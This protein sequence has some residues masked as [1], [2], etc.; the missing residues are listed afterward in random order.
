MPVDRELIL[1]ET[2]AGLGG[3]TQAQQGL[4][5]LNVGAAALAIGLG[6][7]VK[8]GKDAVDNYSSQETA[9]LGLQQAT[10]TQKLNYDKVKGSVEDF[11]QT[12]KAYISN[13]YD[14]IAAAGNIVRAGHDEKDT[15]RLLNDAL[16]L[17]A[18][19]HEDVS[20]AAKQLVL[21]ENGNAKAL[22]ELG[23]STTEYS[24][25]MKNKKL[26]AEQKDAELLALIESK[27][28]N[29]RDAT[30]S[31]KQSQDKLT[32][33]WQNFTTT[34]APQVVSGQNSIN[35]ALDTG[36]QILDL[37]A[38]L[39]QKLPAAYA[40]L[41]S[42]QLAQSEAAAKARG[43]GSAGTGPSPT[44]GTG[45]TGSSGIAQRT[46]HR[47]GGGPVSPGEAYT[48]GES[49]PETLVMGDTG[50]RIIPAGNDGQPIVI[51]NHLHLDGHQIDLFTNVILRRGRFAPGT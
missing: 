35:D 24:D 50:G 40:N 6:L 17:S 49:G 31:L 42:D 19:K 27:T 16:D 10:D 7:L 30:D 44:A 38:Q 2:Q 41:S 8:V 29:G 51:H 18:I 36:V 32:T 22:R 12:N 9:L 46:Q 43:L 39:L 23:I 26:T 4:A 15:M 28:K 13:Q 33:D 45:L 21:A 3:I 25:I 14:V 34:I 5:G 1:I 48:V 11:I 20:E 37:T 47:A